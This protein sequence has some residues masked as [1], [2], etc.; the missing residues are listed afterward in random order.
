MPRSKRKSPKLKRSAAKREPYEL[1][2]IVCEGSETEPNYFENLRETEGLSSV[3]VQITGESGSDSMSVINYA[4]KVYEDREKEKNP[5]TLYDKVYCVIDR[6][7]HANFD[8]A[9][10]KSRGYNYITLIKSYPSFE[11]W[12][13]CHFVYSRASISRS[14]NR[15]AGD[16]CVKTLE[17]HWQSKFGASYTKNRKGIYRNLNGSLDQAVINSKKALKDAKASDEMNPSTEVHSLVEYL[18]KIKK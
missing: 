6:D 17:K 10:N 12:Y 3:N 5:S 9:I 16:N 13:L 2:L 7:S 18:L 14:G 15:S 11:Y 1:I 8:N 4:I